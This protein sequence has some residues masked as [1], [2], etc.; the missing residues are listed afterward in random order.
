[1]VLRSL[2]LG[3]KVRLKGL[4]NAAAY[5]G[6]IATVVSEISAEN[7]RLSVVLDGDD[8]LCRPF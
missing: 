5:N 2:P 7:G 3:S 4:V 8:P 6:L 1:M